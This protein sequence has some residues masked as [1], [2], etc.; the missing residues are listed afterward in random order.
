MRVI[1][2]ASTLTEPPLVA[3]IGYVVDDYGLGHRYPV[4]TGG[5]IP[6]LYATATAV[7]AAADTLACVLC[8]SD[9]G[10]QNLA[11][12]TEVDLINHDARVG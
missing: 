8:Y 10:G 4:Y 9:P 11:V 12:K 6:G 7:L 5:G 2:Q 3:V 1:A